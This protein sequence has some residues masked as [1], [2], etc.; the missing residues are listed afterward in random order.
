MT[1]RF[2]IRP[3]ATGWTVF[4]VWTGLPVE[5]AGAV[6]V[7]LDVEAADDLAD[8]LSDKQDLADN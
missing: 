6:Q 8:L 1:A 5:I 3:D 4:D 7:G 2:S